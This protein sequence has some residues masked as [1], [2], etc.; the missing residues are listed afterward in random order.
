MNE[1]NV[2]NSFRPINNVTL[3][4]MEFLLYN[5]CGKTRKNINA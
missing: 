4:Q 2:I 1:E 5:S 3:S